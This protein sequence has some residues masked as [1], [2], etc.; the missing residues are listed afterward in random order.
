[1][2]YG[3]TC[4]NTGSIVPDGGYVYVLTN[5]A[6]PG[7]VKIGLTRAHPG[8]RAW[9]LSAPTGVPAQFE[10]YGYVSTLSPAMVETDVH[11]R[12]DSHRFSENREFFEIAPEIALQTIEAVVRRTHQ[13]ALATCCSDGDTA[14][15]AALLDLVDY[16]DAT[17]TF[18]SHVLRSYTAAVAR[19]HGTAAGGTTLFTAVE[20]DVAH[21][22]FSEIGVR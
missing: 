13:T 17:F 21:R 7:L 14:M 3:I 16:R 19:S 1:M 18:C 6:M 2:L 9:Q 4:R 20:R 11:Q 10:V 8:T 5:P 12:L 22:L 15:V